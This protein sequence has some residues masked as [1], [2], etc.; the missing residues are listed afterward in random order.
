[1][2]EFTPDTEYVRSKYSCGL[3]SDGRPAIFEKLVKEF[4]RWL[5]DHDAKVRAEALRDA[6]AALDGWKD[7]LVLMVGSESDEGG[8]VEFSIG[9]WLDNRA[10]RIER[11]A[12]GNDD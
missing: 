6:R 7:E 10:D 9:E 3:R 12:V 8:W 1:M 4:D 11:K 2:S 5:A